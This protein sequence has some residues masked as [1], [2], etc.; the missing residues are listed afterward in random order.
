M[1]IK[2]GWMETMD[3]LAWLN[4][5]HELAIRYAAPSII[6]T[7]LIPL[8]AATVAVTSLAGMI[9][10]WFGIKLHTEGPKQFLEVLLKKR[11]LITMLFLNLLGWGGYKS[12]QYFK[13]LPK[14]IMTIELASEKNSI[15]SHQ[16][17]IDNHYR[18][19]DYY[20]ELVSALNV[21]LDLKKE[22][23]LPKGAFR[24][25]V[26][27]GNS[28]FYGVDDG[29]IYELDKFNL[30]IKR[31]FYIGTQVT[32]RPIIYK[33]RIYSGEGNHET[34]HARIYSFDLKSGKF[35]NAFATK[36]HTEGQPLI[37]MHNGQELMF[38]TA[39]SDGLYAISPA[40]MSEIW[41]KNDGH[42]D[43]TV[44]ISDGV[45]YAGTG[46]EKGIS[47][48]K[49][50]A[51]AYEFSTGKEIWKK[52]LPLSNWM[53]PIVT[54]QHV[55]YVLGEIY[56]PSKLGL[57][58]CLDKKTGMTNFS[59][60]TTAPIASK[61]FHIQTDI[62]NYV[63]FGDLEGKIYGININDKKMMWSKSTSL[64]K[65]SYS[66]SSFE[67][68]KDRGVL[69]FPSYNNGIFAIDIKTGDTITHWSP[70]ESQS[71]WRKNYA[72]VSIDNDR[73]YHLDAEGNLRLFKILF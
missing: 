1:V 10:G 33:N 13:T 22:I 14:F 60:S 71:A 20:G 32:T 46:V 18:N 61:P 63:F 44:T 19:H 5:N 70:K 39:G 68:D 21:S 48:N 41:H 38:I 66:L 64:E 49:K 26:I 34:H 52:E 25:G 67:Y 59:L 11:V 29:H 56:S 37:E 6:P 65:I 50:Y 15:T 55:C 54:N 9:A 40:D 17:Y 2:F 72:A 53:H 45:V 24:S 12:Y 27:S 7:V 51:I 73:L 42:L 36:G 69:W 57:F 4:Q 47:N 62:A 8:T 28:L 43:A 30:E 58:H 31:K 3:V 16:N 35:I 23:K